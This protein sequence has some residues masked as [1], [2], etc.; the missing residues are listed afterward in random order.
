[1]ELRS[2]NVGEHRVKSI[3][4]DILSQ[5][6]DDIRLEKNFLTFILLLKS[7][8]NFI[9]SRKFLSMCFTALHYFQSEYSRLFLSKL[10]C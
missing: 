6:T 8:A 2:S 9:L 4:I 1:M 7:F 10:L 3:F 5:A